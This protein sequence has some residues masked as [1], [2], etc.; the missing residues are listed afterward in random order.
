MRPKMTKESAQAMGTLSQK[1]PQDCDAFERTVGFKI[2]NLSQQIEQ[3]NALISDLESQ[4]D[5]ARDT[6]TKSVGEYSGWTEALASYYQSQAQQ[7]DGGPGVPISA[8]GG[9]M[10]EAPN[11]PKTYPKGHDLHVPEPEVTPEPTDG[12]QDEALAAGSTVPDAQGM[13]ATD[14]NADPSA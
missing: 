9:S 7:A 5:E 6:V 1:N 8:P 3:G 10:P 12:P 4:L 11:P 13:A 2:T 14:P